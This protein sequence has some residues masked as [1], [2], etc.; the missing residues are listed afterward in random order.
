V[1]VQDVR[2]RH[3]EIPLQ[4][5]EVIPLDPANVALPQAP[6]AFRPVCVSQCE[7]IEI[8]C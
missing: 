1:V 8:L 2:F 7:V 4:D 6:G 3:R 5:V